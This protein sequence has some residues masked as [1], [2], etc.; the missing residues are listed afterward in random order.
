MIEMM[1]DGNRCVCLK[2]KGR[3]KEVSKE[4]KNEANLIL[5]L[6]NEEMPRKNIYPFIV[7][8]FFFLLFRPL[9]LF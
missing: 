1:V 9:G 8:F 4:K 5:R 3:K 7:F 6:C 2:L